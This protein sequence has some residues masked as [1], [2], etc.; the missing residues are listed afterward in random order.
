M[1]AGPALSLS[2]SVWLAPRSIIVKTVLVVVTALAAVLSYSS[3]DSDASGRGALLFL[4]MV[5][6]WVVA[7][8]TLTIVAIIAFIA[9]MGNTNE[10]R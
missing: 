6:S 7:V 4:H 9:L 5:V 10:S 3:F 1:L 2:L 8:V